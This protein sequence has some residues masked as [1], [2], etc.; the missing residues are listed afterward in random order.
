MNTKKKELFVID[1]LAGKKTLKGRVFVNGAKNSAL[2]AMASSV[3]F[4]GSVTLS[5]IPRTNDIETMVRILTD[6]GAKIDWNESNKT[7]KIDASELS[8]TDIDP[9]LGRTMRASVVLTGPILARLGKVSFPAPGGCVIGAR[10]IDLF[11]EGYKKMGAKISIDDDI[12]SI[13]AKKDGLTSTTIAF[14]R[15]SV[16]GTETLMM[17]AVLSKG[18]TILENCA[19]EPEIVNVAEWLNACGANI[20]GV[21]TPIITI[22]GTNG[23]L[24]KPKVSYE[25]IPDRIEAGSFLV[26][27]ALCAEKLLI[28][29]CRPDHLDTVINI[30]RES[31]VNISTS[32]RSITVENKLN[33]SYKAVNIQTHEYPGF[34]TDLQVPMAI[35]LT[36]ASGQ[37]TV[38]ETI[39][40]GRLKYVDDLKRM[41]ADVPVMNPMEILIKGPTP[42]KALS[43]DEEL[44]AYDIRAGFAI[45]LAALVGK[46]KFIINNIHLIDR[47]YENLEG[48]L[49]DIGANISR[50]CTSG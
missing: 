33:N 2:K 35:F 46:G 24:L 34:P 16:G 19:M 41:G 15:V 42:L 31:G 48:R 25:A 8:K 27:G 38:I 49:R 37:S 11:I 20:T 12:Y 39:F 1:G 36:Q 29:N 44:F 21:G 22:V 30:L 6:L 40:E 47:G 4:D 28:E 9:D 26:L 32:E 13:V 5:N 18:T 23:R 10:P 43:D 7:M 45:V 50:C 17:S 14:N 3:L